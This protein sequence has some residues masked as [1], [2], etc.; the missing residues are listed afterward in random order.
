MLEIL[1]GE[2]V[3]GVRLA[4]LLF[5]GAF[6]GLE[7]LGWVKD[8]PFIRMFGCGL[9]LVVRLLAVVAVVLAAA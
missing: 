2:D 4:V 5:V 3:V 9:W 8:A 1:V 6:D 7:I